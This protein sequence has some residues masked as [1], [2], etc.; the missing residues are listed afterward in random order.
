M[1]ASRFSTE[2]KIFNESDSN[3]LSLALVQIR[4]ELGYKS[5]RSFFGDYLQRRTRLD[6]NY[7]YYMKIEGAK[8][9]PSPQV[10]SDLCRSLK[11]EDSDTIHLAYCQAIFPERA[12]LFRVQRKEPVKN[13]NQASTLNQK[14]L[15]LAQIACIG[16]SRT[17]YYVFLL[18]T[19]ARTSVSRAALAQEVGESEIDNILRGL[20]KSKLIRIDGDWAETI[21]QEMRFP[22]PSSAQEKKLYEQIES[23]NLSFPQDM[24]F[25]GLLQKMLI[26]R[27]S[28]RYL[29]LILSHCNVLLDLIRTSDETNP[30]HN[31]DV[32]MLKLSIQ[33]GKLPG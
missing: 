11:I 19:L 7:S 28:P 8:T 1:I 26:R 17:H 10:I 9:L 13:G 4:K 23:W 15:T 5:A 16:Q 33:Q 21:S 18:L 30:E 32:L 29:S 6:F 25:E 2:N 20:E 22:E 3:P 14:Y 12:R 24:E 27:V 31:E